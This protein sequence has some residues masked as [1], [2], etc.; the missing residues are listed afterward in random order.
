MHKRQ[1]GKDSSIH[2]YFGLLCWCNKHRCNITYWILY[3]GS[4]VQW[5][6]SPDG[7]WGCLAGSTILWVCFD[8]SVKSYY[9]YY[10]HVQIIYATDI[11]VHQKD[12][13]GLTEVCDAPCGVWTPLY[14]SS[15]VAWLFLTSRNSLHSI[16][17]FLV[18]CIYF[19]LINFW[20]HDTSIQI[21]SCVFCMHK[22]TTS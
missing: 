10:I 1:Q 16:C 12:Q 19:N 11:D 21:V 9:F 2:C 5:L 18:A 15:T 17:S 6:L 20:S 7:N 22:L 14:S 8:K 3:V 4:D 13:S